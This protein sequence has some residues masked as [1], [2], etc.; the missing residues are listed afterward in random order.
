MKILVLEPYFGGSHKRFLQDLQNILPH[1]FHFLTLPARKWKWRMRFSAPWFA[2]KL[3]DLT[4]DFEIILCSTFVDV[5]TFRGLAPKW[6]SNIPIYTYFHENQFAYPVQIEDERDY[7]FA[8]TNLTTAASSDS[9]AFNSRYNLKTFLSGCEDMVKKAPD[10]KLDIVDSIRCKS[11][12]LYPG[13]N[14]S[15]LDATMRRKQNDNIPVIVWNHRWEHDKNP[16]FF[17]KTL[18]SLDEEG[19][20]FKLIILGQSFTRQPDIFNK[21]KQRL[22][23][24]ILHF[25]YEK[26]IEKYYSLLKCGSLVV[27]TSTHEFYGMSVIEAV[28][29][30][31]R[32]L[33]PCRLSYPELFPEN[34]L[35]K[36]KVLGERMKKD[37]VQG[38]LDES[39]A[40]KLTDL[41]S[42]D[43]LKGDYQQWL[44]TSHLT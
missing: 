33:L 42:W 6:A 7:H 12:V 17:F 38:P 21:V 35:Y 27:S 8:L 24:R 18:F 32:P 28:R 43:Y 15:Q 23:H 40:R 2:E 16:E 30:G 10:M 39:V 25:G 41:F 36:D 20:E 5:S 34:F 26:N 3:K 9:V 14:F 29:A 13:M 22:A 1:H 31:C 11:K 37:L 4:P 44:T 19:F